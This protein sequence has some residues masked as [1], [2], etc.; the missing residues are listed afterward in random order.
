[1][2]CRAQLGAVRKKAIVPDERVEIR[3]LATAKLA[4]DHRLIN[5]RTAAK[6]LSKLKEVIEFGDSLGVSPGKII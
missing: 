5:G 3:P 4:V 2:R 6:F 1:M